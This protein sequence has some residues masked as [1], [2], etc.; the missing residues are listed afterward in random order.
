M[1]SIVLIALLS[2]NVAQ[3]HAEDEVASTD[4]NDSQ[5]FMDEFADELM[6]KLAN[7][8]VDRVQESFVDSSDLDSATMGK[9]GDLE[10]PLHA[11]LPVQTSFGQ[12]QEE[13]PSVA[14]FD[15]QQESMLDW[16]LNLRGGA[17]AA[18][19]K[20]A[21][22]SPMKAMKKMNEYF[23]KMTEAKKTGAKSFEYN[24]KTYVASKTKTGLVVYKAK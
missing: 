17:K 24:G 10:I 23:T 19:M 11:N 4:M 14:D 1:L 15:D 6:Q 8:L 18:P 20:A 21:P 7:R 22:K 2:F 9:P 5:D 3:V 16:M 13:D 12:D